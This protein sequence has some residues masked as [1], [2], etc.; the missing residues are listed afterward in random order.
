MDSEKD[1]NEEQRKRAKSK[2]VEE[3][4]VRGQKRR[5]VYSWIHQVVMEERKLKHE[6]ERRKLSTEN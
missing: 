5:T 1:R 4:H 2:D 3:G 6:K